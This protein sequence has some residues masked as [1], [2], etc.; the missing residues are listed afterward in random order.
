MHTIIIVLDPAK[1]S[2]PDLDLRYVIPERIET[3]SNGAIQDDGYDYIDTEGSSSLGI[4]LKT[5]SAAENWPLILKLFQDETF[6]ENDLSLSAE[7]F[8]SENDGE[9]IS[10]CTLVYSPAPSV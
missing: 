5:E 2:N 8:I 9:D 7:I 4:F 6:M 3:A 10:N 1:L